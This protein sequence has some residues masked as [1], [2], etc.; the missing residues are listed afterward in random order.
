MDSVRNFFLLSKLTLVRDSF[1]GV[2]HFLDSLFEVFSKVVDRVSV[3]LSATASSMT[4]GLGVSQLDD[5]VNA[6]L[7]SICLQDLK[8]SNLMD[9]E[10]KEDLVS[11]F[12]EGLDNFGLPRFVSF[13]GLGAGAGATIG[14]P[15]AS[16]CS[17]GLCMDTASASLKKCGFFNKRPGRLIDH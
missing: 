4:V 16:E 15:C 17:S 1:C 5:I 2:A 3:L 11:F 14:F 8:E 12:S 10:G 9:S 6:S 13:W 7:V